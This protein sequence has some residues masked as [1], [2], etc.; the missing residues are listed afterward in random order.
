MTLKN[1]VNERKTNK[2]RNE[3]YKTESRT[4]ILDSKMTW[5]CRHDCCV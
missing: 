2:T 5:I 4:Y 1:K 3:I